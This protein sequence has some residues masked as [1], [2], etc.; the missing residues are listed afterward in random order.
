MDSGVDGLHTEKDS[1]G[2]SDEEL[3]IK[4]GEM[5]SCNRGEIMRSI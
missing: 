3:H 4:D 2:E 5:S 1:G